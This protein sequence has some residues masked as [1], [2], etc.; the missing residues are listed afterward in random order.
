MTSNGKVKCIFMFICEFSLLPKSI[1][2]WESAFGCIHSVLDCHFY[3]T[4][5]KDWA[6]ILHQTPRH[7]LHRGDIK[8]FKK[9]TTTRPENHGMCTTTSKRC[10]PF[11]YN[12]I[13]VILQIWATQQNHYKKL[14]PGGLP[15]PSWYCAGQETDL[16]AILCLTSISVSWSNIA[17]LFGSLFLRH[18][19]KSNLIWQKIKIRQTL[20]IYYLLNSFWL[21]A[22]EMLCAQ[23]K[24]SRMCWKLSFIFLLVTFHAEKIHVIIE[25][26]WILIKQTSFITFILTYN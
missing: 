18:G 10:W 2:C 21:S 12:P 25:K 7:S 19:A 23:E 26:I 11:S 3:K 8:Q 16:V 24:T 9:V 14:L 17:F 22:T 13:G 6:V 20:S 15:S 4:T 5:Y 1:S